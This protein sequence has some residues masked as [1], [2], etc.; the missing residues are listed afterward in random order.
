MDDLQDGE[1]E[2]D[3]GEVSSRG[4]TM[5]SIVFRDLSTSS[6]GSSRSS[7]PWQHAG[8]SP[9]LAMFATSSFGGEPLRVLANVDEEL[10]AAH[11][12]P[13]I[14]KRHNQKHVR[15]RVRAKIDASH[16]VFPP[17]VPVKPGLESARGSGRTLVSPSTS[18]GVDEQERLRRTDL[19][20]LVD[21]CRRCVNV[22]AIHHRVSSLDELPVSPDSA[23]ATT[24]FAAVQARIAEP[25]TWSSSNSHRIITD[26]FLPNGLQDPPIDF[27]HLPASL[28][29]Q[30]RR[31]VLQGLAQLLH[32]IAGASHS[33]QVSTFAALL[34]V[35][36]LRPTTSV[37]GPTHKPALQQFFV[38][39]LDAF[40][41]LPNPSELLA[42]VLANAN[43]R[44]GETDLLVDLVGELVAM[45]GKQM[46]A[47]PT[48]LSEEQDRTLVTV[49]SF[50]S[51]CFALNS[52][53]PAALRLHAHAFYCT[54]LDLAPFLEHFVH[55]AASLARSNTF[56]PAPA[57]LAEF[58][59]CRS[60]F[61]LSLGAKVRV[62][63]LENEIRLSRAPLRDS[64]SPQRFAL[65]DTVAE[66]VVLPTSLNVRIEREHA[67]EQSKS[68]FVQ[69]LA[70]EATVRALR[71]EFAH[72]H[73]ADGG[74]PAREWFATVA[75]GWTDYRNLVG[76]HG[77]FIAPS[78]TD[79]LGDA[80]DTST[81]LGFLLALAALHTT[82]LALPFTLP[83]VAFKIA[84]ARD[85]DSLLLTP[86]DLEF[87][88]AALAKSLQAVLDWEPP[89]PSADGEVDKVFDATFSLSWSTNLRTSV[90]EIKTIDL[91]PGGRHRSVRLADRREFVS[92]LIWRV[93]VGSVRSQ[94][95][96][97]RHGWQSIMSTPRLN[98]SSGAGGMNGNGN[99]NKSPETATEILARGGVALSL[100]SPEEVGQ[101]M[102]SHA[103]SA[104]A[105]SSASWATLDIDDI[106]SATD[107]VYPSSAS[108]HDSGVVAWFWTL[109]SSLDA[110]HQRRM[111]AFVT[112]AEEVPATGAKGIGLRI[113][114]VSTEVMD[115]RS[116]PLPWS[117][118]CT[119]TL[120]LPTYPSE[121]LL[122]QKVAIAIEHY[123]GFGLR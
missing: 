116:W 89:C 58:N 1:G 77:W 20:K 91:V 41:G 122:R 60:P 17:D 94:V 24:L 48:V 73:A 42:S 108:A 21:E 38:Q 34:S 71:V 72:E 110:V 55:H 95:H 80:E 3:I 16:P 5:S 70:S 47:N 99:G 15:N 59:V 50:L 51:L 107:V 46:S 104:A 103:S 52:T 81:F 93:L 112:G 11:M 43:V 121:L 25:G 109:W 83:A 106:R 97:F 33:E 18:I 120:F 49:S 118:T 54:V 76:S 14:Y 36:S 64:S 7:S 101:A 98:G 12:G 67:W 88:D 32:T 87:A 9:G 29:P 45:C 84:A 78:S 44:D 86:A 62:L 123:Q 10:G 63:Q 75:S 37:D 8:L 65:P 2:N 56:V 27:S 57:G 105:S 102:V 82:K 19:Q 13:R 113:L 119:S 39:L 6:A 26:N 31:S 96:A 28:L 30:M 114:L 117:S 79:Q 66:L 53:R 92:K 69:L 90:G 74:G 100:F 35:R 4:A 23:P 115:P 85:L 40:L 68:L 22:A 111:L 61:L